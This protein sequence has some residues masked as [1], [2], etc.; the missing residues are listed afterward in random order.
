MHYKPTRDYI[1]FLLGEKPTTTNAIQLPD[2]AKKKYEKEL[3]ESI[4]GKFV[5]VVA[6]GE[7]CKE[8]KEG[9][10]VMLGNT[11]VIPVEFDGLMYGTV[12]EFSVIGKIVN[13]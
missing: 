5:E 2:A 9:D 1:V 3:Q 7:A 10:K 13:E 4:S 11:I 6:V 12:P 8:I